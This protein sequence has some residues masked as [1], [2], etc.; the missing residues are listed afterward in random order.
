MRYNLRV[1]RKV[2]QSGGRSGGI[3]LAVCITVGNQEGAA[4]KKTLSAVAASLHYLVRKKSI[5]LRDNPIN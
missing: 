3:Q 1:K 2:D 4:L 5:D